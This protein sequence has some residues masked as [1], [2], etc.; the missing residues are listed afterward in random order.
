MRLRGGRYDSPTSSSRRVWNDPKWGGSRRIRVGR[1]V[2]CRP[3]DLAVEGQGDADD[4]SQHQRRKHR[5]VML[6]PN[7]PAPYTVDQQSIGMHR[8]PSQMRA[9]PMKAVVRERRERE[10][11]PLPDATLAEGEKNYRP[12]VLQ[13]RHP[14]SETLQISTASLTR[15]TRCQDPSGL[16][17]TQ[18][19]HLHALSLSISPS[20]SLSLF[21]LHT[22]PCTSWE[23]WK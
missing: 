14:A 9:E 13:A 10:S 7:L 11:C 6:V 23:L 20:L 15:R 16:W 8:T 2:L 18:G 19:P 3:R 12:S 22:Y 4:A 1:G 17:P 5:R 21:Y